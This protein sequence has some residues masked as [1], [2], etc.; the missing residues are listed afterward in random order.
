M[1]EIDDIDDLSGE[2]VLGTLAPA[3]RAEVAARRLRE[4]LLDEAILYWEK[5]LAP[6]D[7]ATP[8][9]T[10]EPATWRSILARLDA[11]TVGIENATV[12]DLTRRLKRWRT[13]ALASGALAA[14]IAIG[15]AWRETDLR[16]PQGN[17][18]AVLQHDAASPAFIVDV[19]LRSRQVSVRPV[20]AAHAPGKSYELWLIH[21]S[22][23]A[24]QSLGVVA[25][26][27]FTVR[28]SLANYDRAAIENGTYAVTLEPEGGSPNGKPSAPPLW[29]GKLIQA[30]P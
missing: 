30:T 23:G 7:D 1:S 2:Y 5:C 21:D 6:L 10:P 11:H 24:P 25:D 16:A 12:I 29:T 8:E 22:L 19:D 13:A 28:P 9:I 14:C 4:P 20:A 18:V 3:E 17:F 27:G 26:Q 15:F